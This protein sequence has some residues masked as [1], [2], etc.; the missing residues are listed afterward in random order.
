MAEE[1]RK[2]ILASY[3]TSSV[4]Q[5]YI[6]VIQCVLFLSITLLAMSLVLEG[7]ARVAFILGAV[8][9]STGGIVYYRVS[10]ARAIRQIIHNSG[11]K[12][13]NSNFHRV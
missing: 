11:D 13:K 7:V 10:V 2:V 3:A 9:V 8:L 5:R 12:G 4:A 1:Q 6:R